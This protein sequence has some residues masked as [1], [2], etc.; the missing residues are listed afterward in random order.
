LPKSLQSRRTTAAA[1]ISFSPTILSRLYHFGGA[2]PYA[3]D[4]G[5]PGPN[6]YNDTSATNYGVDERADVGL[7]TRSIKLTATIPAND[8]K[9]LH[10]GGE[11]IIRQGFTEVS[12]QGAELQKF[13]K[14]LRGSYPIHLHEDGVM[15]SAQTLLINANSIDHI[16]NKCITVDST[17]NVSIT[18]NVCARVVGHIF[19]EEIGDEQNIAFGSNLGLGAMSNFFDINNG[20]DLPRST[21]ITKYWWPG[22]NLVNTANFNYDGFRIPDT[23]KQ[24][25]G[26]AGRCFKFQ[27]DKEININSALVGADPAVPPCDDGA[28]YAEPPTGFWIVNPSAILIGNSI[29]GCQ[30]EGKGYWYVPPARAQ[31]DTGKNYKSVGFIPVGSYPGLTGLHGQFTNNRVHGCYSG[32]YSGDSED[33]TAGAM[34]PY[35]N[36]VETNSHPVMGEFDGLTATRLRNR[37]AWLRPNFF[38]LKDARFATNRDS[39]SLVTSGGP[40]GNYPGIYSLMTDSVVVGVS[41]NNVDRWGPCPLQINGNPSATPPQVSGQVRGW[42]WGCIDQTSALKGQNGPGGDLIGNA[43]PGNNWNF[44][45][46]MI[47]DGPVLIF[48]DRFV[49]FKQNP[50]SLLT[51][52]DAA[53]LNTPPPPTPPPTNGPYEGD[54]ALGWYQGNISSYPTANTSEQLT[55]DNVDFR[56]Q[57]YTQLVNISSFNDGDKNTTIL[58]RDGT[59]SGYQV[60]SSADPSTVLTDVPPI[61]LN[62]LELNAGGGSADSGPGGSVDECEA[63]GAQDIKLEGR[64]TANLSPGEVGALEFMAAYPV[65]PPSPPA[66]TYRSDQLVTF[67]KDSLEFGGSDFEEH[68]AMTLVG[69]DGQGVWEPKVTSGYGYTITASTA[70]PAP[71]GPPTAP[72][73]PDGFYPEDK[74]PPAGIPKLVHVGVVDVGKPRISSTNPFYVR[75]GI[76]YTGAGKSHPP[77]P[78]L[79][80]VTQGY[81][82]WGG[83]GVDATDPLLRPYYNQLDGKSNGLKD[84]QY[85]FNLDHQNPKDLT[86]CPSVGV[87][88][89][90]PISPNCPAGSIVDS[91]GKLCIYPKQQLTAAIAIDCSDTVNNCLTN[92]DGTPNL[93]K[94]FYDPNTGWLFFYVAQIRPNATGPNGGPAPLG[95]CSGNTATDP[96]FCPSQNGGE[97]YYVCPPEGCWSYSVALNDPNYS[98]E[99]SACDDPYPTYAQ[100]TPVLE[101]QLAQAGTPVTRVV[102]GG[103]GGNFP[104][105]L[106]EDLSAGVCPN[107]STPTPAPTP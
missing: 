61:S 39:V 91:T 40:D 50:A 90:L 72:Y 37:G 105:Y 34:F 59:L 94:Y 15:S 36:G 4:G 99:P 29:G 68:P 95:S 38:T 98:P 73:C 80:T 103:V 46:D 65:G 71:P 88:P 57:V 58:D 77:D 33:I 31:G 60:V 5:A 27:P 62:N 74:C 12:I 83:G 92:T 102:D 16:Y 30:G 3:A 100:D 20:T 89:A 67:T 75:V 93:D 56:H 13:G 84:D 107:V 101:G 24:Q 81:R 96:F 66:G 48:N 86:Y 76:C 55:F 104:H 2:N 63:T 69:R 64:A 85:C 44:F 78:G 97:S 51:T 42:T 52:T 43:L 9:S 28:I 82:S 6:G 23:D 11:I 106:D 32:L 54:A 14:D 22:D 79:F 7:I 17:T 35:L 26:A 1:L 21:L 41:Q 10:W 45:G 70:P 8:P 25:N 53:Y 49:N 19:Y 87:T 47:Y 18:N